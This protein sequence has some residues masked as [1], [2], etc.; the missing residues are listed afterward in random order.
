MASHRSVLR[1]CAV[2]SWGLV[3]LLVSSPALGV[4]GELVRTYSDPAGDYAKVGMSLDAYGTDILAGAP[5]DG[6]GWIFPGSVYL[7]DTESGDMI[8]KY[9]N[10]NQN[11]VSSQFAAAACTVG[12]R[13]LAGASEIDTDVQMS[14]AAYLFDGPTAELDHTL[15]AATPSMGEQAGKSVAAYGPYCLVGA[16][17][18]DAT[19][20]INDWA[21]KVYMYDPSDG[22][23]MRTFDNPAP[24]YDD[25]FGW[26]VASM[27]SNVLIGAPGDA[28]ETTRSG[29]VYLFDGQ[30]GSQLQTFAD[31]TPSNSDFFGYALASSG[32]TVF[33]GAPFGGWGGVYAYAADTGE[34]QQAYQNPR[35]AADAFGCSIA[36]VGEYLLVGAYGGVNSTG[37]SA[38]LFHIETG[39]LVHT[40]IDPSPATHDGF[41]WAVCGIGSDYAIGDPY[42]D[43]D[44][45][46][47]GTVYLYEGVPQPGLVASSGFGQGLAGWAI[48]GNGTCNLVEDPHAPGN[49]AVEMATGSPVTIS[50][51]VDTPGMA[52]WLEFD[53]EFTE[54]DGF[55][56]LSLAGQE[57]DTLLAPATLVE[58][59]TTYSLLVDA[60]ELIALTDATLTLTLD[61]ATVG[62]ILLDNVAMVEVPEPA[63]LSLLALGSLAMIRRRRR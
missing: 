51:S 11:A 7:F 57:L 45:I 62:R 2:V 49:W 4:I 53:Y 20:N 25:M 30:T 17:Y 38:Y 31:P 59:W 5:G 28:W 47:R 26:S 39:D 34:F 8:R 44:G 48:E 37:G 13:V 43:G 15:L 56:T 46:S 21:G 33:V 61:S 40:F 52:F 3:L 12:S 22:S 50:Q 54:T 60:S 19:S 9:A 27:G 24:A 23:V 41:G 63:T 14:G 32:N 58:G 16:P 18:A 36:V 55:L 35:A 10:P 6:P 29:Q 1:F 42:E